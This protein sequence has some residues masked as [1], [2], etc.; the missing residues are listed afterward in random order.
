MHAGGSDT[1]PTPLEL[2]SAG[3]A[4]CVALYTHKYCEE[5]GLETEGLAAEVRPLWRDNRIARF[6]VILHVP[7]AID[8]SEYAGLLD[9]AQTCPVH[10]TL[11]HAPEINV[12]IA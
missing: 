7:A 12:R 8:P 3:L 5:N 4:G 9:V 2:I 6:D 11:T 1:A 10:N